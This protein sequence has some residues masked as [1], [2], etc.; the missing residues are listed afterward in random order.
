MRNHLLAI[1]TAALTLVPLMTSCSSDVVDGSPASSGAGAGQTTT[2]QGGSGG[3]GAAGQGGSGAGAGGQGGGEV[4]GG[5]SGATCPDTQFCDYPLDSC[6]AADETGICTTRPN[7]CDTSLDPICACDGMIY[8]N[9][10]NAHGA[11]QDVSLRGG[12]TIDPGMFAC[13]PRICNAASEYC[14]N[15]ASAGP[16]LPDAYSCQPLPSPCNMMS[17][18]N[19]TCMKPTADDCGGGCTQ[20]GMTGGITISCPPS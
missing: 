16:N 20:D 19:C 7:N 14:R 6:G 18:A 3:E 2:A 15:E 1:G 11:G 12:C 5:F 9:T 13:G 8:G 10:C 17:V 4:C